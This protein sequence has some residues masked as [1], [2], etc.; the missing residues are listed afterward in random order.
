MS[1]K[2]LDNSPNSRG[3]LITL[4]VAFVILYILY[5]MAMDQWP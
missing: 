2:D 5:K 4:V 1:D 3:Y